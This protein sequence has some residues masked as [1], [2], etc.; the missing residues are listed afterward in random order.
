MSCSLLIITIKD[1]ILTI[2]APEVEEYACEVLIDAS[3]GVSYARNK[4]AYLASGDI[5]VFMD[6]DIIPDRSV[7]E[8]IANIRHRE[9]MMV[10]GYRH[11]ITRIMAIHK[12]DFNDIGGFDENIRYNGE[13]LD[14]YWIAL[15]KGYIISTIPK[16]LV[17]HEPHGK[18]NWFKYHFESAYTRVKHDRIS[19]DFFVQTN[20][21]I[22]FLRLT[23]FIYHSMRKK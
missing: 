11:P 16:C 4:L 22:A 3:P 13:D 6:D 17:S 18:S 8:L 14:F 20:P 1:H 19:L 2:L 7:W 23:G 9:I 5:L 15:E 21:V 12:D 10:E